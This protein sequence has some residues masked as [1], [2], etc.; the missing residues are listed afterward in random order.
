MQDWYLKR[1]KYRRRE[2]TPDSYTDW[3]VEFVEV[4]VVAGGKP[5]GEA[6]VPFGPGARERPIDLCNIRLEWKGP[7]S[8][9]TNPR[10]NRSP[11]QHS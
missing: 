11:L 8:R 3:V 6:M 7:W 1:W 9:L 4:L 2:V 10:P 5:S